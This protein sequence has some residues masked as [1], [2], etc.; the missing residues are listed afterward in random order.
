MRT[1][2]ESPPT[3]R[4]RPEARRVS[5][6]PYAGPSFHCEDGTPVSAAA[7]VWLDA[8]GACWAVMET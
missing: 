6:S 2:R 8:D 4:G 1:S 3:R 5:F 7:L